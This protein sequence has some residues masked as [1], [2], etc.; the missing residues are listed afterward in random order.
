MKKWD[1]MT[2][3]DFCA[4]FILRGGDAVPEFGQKEKMVDSYSVNMG[5]SA[6]IFSCQCA[7]LGLR[8]AA[9]D[10]LGED[11]FGRLI[12]DELGRSGVDTGFI[13]V[14][15]AVTTGVTCILQKPDDRAM[16]TVSGSIGAAA[17]AD[18]PDALKKN[19]RHLHIASYYLMDQLRSGYPDFL[20]ELRANGVT[21]SLDTNWDPAEKWDGLDELLGL[22]DVFLP[23]ENEICAVTGERDALDGMRKLASRVPVVAVKLGRR[24]AAAVAEGREYRADALSVP[25]V[26]AVG[27][28]DSFDGGFIAGWLN[29]RGLGDCLALGCYCGSMNVARQGGTA[30]QPRLDSLPANL[31][32]GPC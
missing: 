28:G 32:G 3:A 9:V 29:G 19:V 16:L 25:F 11:V 15:T 1:V 21:V 2:F 8:T 12:L 6:P 20:R 10:K 4:D 31:K 5:G 17:F 7:K 18:A 22:V 14:D 24:G 23:N 27:A 13:R 30:G 26:D